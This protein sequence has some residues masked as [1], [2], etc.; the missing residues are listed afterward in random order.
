MSNKTTCYNCDKEISLDD[1]IGLYNDDNPYCKECAGYLEDRAEYY[2]EI[3]LEDR[4]DAIRE[5]NS[6]EMS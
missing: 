1:A 6:L 2:A 4:A 3:E 5:H